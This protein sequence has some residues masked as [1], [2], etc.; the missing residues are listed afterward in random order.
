MNGNISPET[1]Y[2]ELGSTGEKV[3]CIGVGGS[4]LRGPDVDEK[5][6][7]AIVRGA[8]PQLREHRQRRHPEGARRLG[9][10]M[11]ALRA[12]PADVRRLTGI[13]SRKVVD[14]AIRMARTF[15]PLMDAERRALLERTA[16]SAAGGQF[17]LFKTTSVFDGTAQ[18]SDWLGEEPK[19]VA[20]LAP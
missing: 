14:Q 6:A 13:D 10:G 1:Q 2:R 8:L 17:E 3:S 15:E 20:A 16:V 4:H 18:N 5:L 9:R 11:P 12:Q 7:I 19:A